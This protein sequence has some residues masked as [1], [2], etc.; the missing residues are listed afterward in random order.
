MKPPLL[1]PPQKEA[2]ERERKPDAHLEFD[3][4]VTFSH[5]ITPNHY[6]TTQYY[7]IGPLFLG[8]LQMEPATNWFDESFATFLK[9]HERFARQHRSRP[10]IT[11]HVTSANSRK[12]HQ[13]SGIKNIVLM[14]GQGPTKTNSEEPRSDR[15]KT[16][17]PSFSLSLR[18]LEQTQEISLYSQTP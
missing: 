14:H 16:Y 4:V 6:F 3:F 12:D 5:T 2:G 1:N 13:L 17:L 18:D 10:S 9:S 11:Y 8:T 15:E 7:Y